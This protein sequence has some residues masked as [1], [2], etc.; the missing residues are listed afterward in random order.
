LAF[1]F[2]AASVL[3]TAE[4]CNGVGRAIGCHET[5]APAKTRHTPQQWNSP[6]QGYRLNT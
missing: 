2:P 6:T 1:L 3:M 5:T 4:R